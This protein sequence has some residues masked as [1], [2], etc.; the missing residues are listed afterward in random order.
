MREEPIVTEEYSRKIRYFS[1]HVELYHYMKFK[2][3]GL[4]S[5]TL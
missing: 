4:N 3:L 2:S 5:V 1:T